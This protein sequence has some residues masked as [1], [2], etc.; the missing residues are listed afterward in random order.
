VTVTFRPMLADD[1]DWLQERTLAVPARDI[2]GVVAEVDGQRGAV[3][4]AERWTDT[5]CFMHLVVDD[6][7]VLAHNTLLDEIAGYVFGERGKQFMLSTVSSLNEAS[8]KFQRG[9]GFEE[10]ARVADA[11]DV[12][13]DLI[14]MRLTRAEWF[15]RRGH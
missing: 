5:S 10:V 13:E 2:E 7:R 12:G 11:F 15:K 8:V 1:L 4:G 14:I 9:I 6:P 3:V